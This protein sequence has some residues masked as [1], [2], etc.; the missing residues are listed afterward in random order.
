MS[1]N[2]AWRPTRAEVDL[3]C[4][5]HNTALLRGMVGL[6]CEIM[7]VVKADG[8]GHGA[9]QAARAALQAGASRLGVALVEEA[10]EL[11]AA[12][13]DAPVHLLFE[14]HPAAA[15]RVADLSLTPSVYT[16]TWARALSRAAGD[17][18]GELGVHLKV[19][20]GMH[21]VGASP[22]EA[23]GLAEEVASLPGLRLEGAYTHLANASQPGDPFN[24]RQW[25]TFKR[26]LAGLERRGLRV[27]LRHAAAS[28]AAICF[29]ESRL[30][31]VRIGI[32]MYGLLPGAA[33]RGML[34]LR[35]A[36]SLKTEVGHVFRASEAEGVS[37]GLT[38]RCERDAWIAALPLGYADGIPRA[39]SNRWE[40]TIAGKSYPQVGTVC[41]DL[42]MVDLGEDRYEP[43]EEVTF[44]AAYGGG[45]NGAERMAELLGTINYEVV[46][47]IGKRVPRVHLNRL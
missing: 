40:V 22:G 7:A 20:T 34:D 33:C 21:R 37:Y 15:R 28:A 32:S 31:M 10:E 5:R 24:S 41:M 23:A 13:V 38:Y 35:P 8:Y 46:C 44:I 1:G 19:D 26:V 3:E 16:R 18:G 17:R 2:I 29:P 42:C 12:G 14:P 36:L 6:S 4:I 47:G 30:D 45:A 25:E 9:V 43:G 11:R 27:A 39:L